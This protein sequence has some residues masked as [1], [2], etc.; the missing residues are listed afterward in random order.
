MLMMV[1]PIVEV[2][3]AFFCVLQGVHVVSRELLKARTSDQIEVGIRLATLGY[4]DTI[5][6]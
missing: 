1:C 3:T 5:I 4:N 2:N 6:L